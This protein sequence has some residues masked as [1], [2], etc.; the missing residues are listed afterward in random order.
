MTAMR[1][2]PT[3]YAP[4]HAEYV[5]LVP[6]EEIVSA[7]EQQ[8]SE[9]QK[10]LSSLDES[11]AAFRYADDKWSVKEVLGHVIDSERI[12]AYRILAIAR[13]ETA[14]L[15][16]YEEND[17]VRAAHFDS[18]RLT[19][20]AEHYALTR[21]S[22]IVLLSNLPEEAW[23]RRG[24]ANGNAVT[25]RALAWIIVGHERHHVSVLRERYR[26]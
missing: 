7:M 11:K 21:R 12:F 18:W 15:P 16:G 17:Y 5:A 24:T 9:T 26:V 3:D 2:A 22:N 8:S 13:G 19:D 1:P 23:D 25:A 14:S 20:L 6:E 4:A 10:L